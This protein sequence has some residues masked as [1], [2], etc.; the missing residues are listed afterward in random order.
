MTQI[1]YFLPMG[2]APDLRETRTAVARVF[3]IV[4]D[5]VQSLDAV[6]P[7]EVFG[8]A[9]RERAGVRYVVSLVSTTGGLVSTSTGFQLL[10]TT[11][12]RVRAGDRVIIAGG[13]E[14]GLRAALADDAL[15]GWVRRAA[16][17][18]GT[19]A[20]VC[21][22]A[23]LLAHAGVLD[24]LRAATHWEACDRLAAFRPAVT[25]DRDAIFV[26][27]GRVWTS[28]GVTTGIDMAL[29]M[30]EADHDAPLA[31]AVAARLVLYARRPGFQSQFSDALV[32]QTHAHDPLGPAI[33]WGRAHLKDATIDGLA[34]HAGMSLRTFH[35]RCLAL[36]KTTPAKLLERL[37]VEHARTLLGAGEASAKTIAARAG[38]GTAARM[39]RA[40]TRE[41]G[42]KPREYRL[43]FGRS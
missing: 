10:T 23:F 6:G 27:E 12:P 4:F 42:I 43:L 13:N 14:A 25:V 7:A 35:R 5:G 20:S 34:R 15:M 11:L 39:N 16:A 26:R 21:S 2:R 22:G 24:G 41:L 30:V 29:A 37:R 33:A 3:V 1:V 17:R 9:S 40:F 28:A 19:I 32:A 18:A 31:D 8:T 38:F 36:L